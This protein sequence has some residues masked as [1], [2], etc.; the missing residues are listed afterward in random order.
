M[1][2]LV[3]IGLTSLSLLFGTA[4]HVSGEMVLATSYSMI[5]GSGQ[6]VDGLYNY[7]DGNYTILANNTISSNATI[8]GAFLSGGR[9]KLTDGFISTRRFDEV[10][11]LVGTGEYVGWRGQVQSNPLITFDFDGSP[12]IDEINIYI[13]NSG[14]G[15]VIAPGSVLIDGVSRPFT[16]PVSGTIGKVV[17]AGLG[18]TGSRHTVQLNQILGSWVF[19]SE[20]TFSSVS[21]PEP[22]SFVLAALG[23][24]GVNVLRRR[25]TE[26]NR[27]LR[28]E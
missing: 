19:A 4:S 11:N 16:P 13:D 21:T 17:F 23:L 15:N 8:A 9:G 1:R 24:T 6:N 3:A 26:F 25:R 2:S 12:F 20:I 22:S 7:W 14:F 18:L 27:S 28:Q 5:N 10:S